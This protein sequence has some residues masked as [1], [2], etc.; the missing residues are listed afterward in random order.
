MV[1]VRGHWASMVEVTQ[2]R[3]FVMK[4]YSEQGSLVPISGETD[5][6]P[7]AAII[8]SVISPGAVYPKF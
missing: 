7:V 3:S 1:L 4:N 5:G 6:I 8:Q 2:A